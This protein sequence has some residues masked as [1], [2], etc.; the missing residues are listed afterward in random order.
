[1]TT[2]HATAHA[3]KG[4]G[5]IYFGF[6]LLHLNPWGL[7]KH[8]VASK[9]C[10]VFSRRLLNAR[11]F[12]WL[13]MVC[14]KQG[15]PGFCPCVTLTI[16]ALHGELQPEVV[17]RVHHPVVAG[18][19]DVKHQPPFLCS[20]DRPGVQQEQIWIP[21]AKKQSSQSARV[22]TGVSGRIL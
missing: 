2:D 16:D 8:K 19:G 17:L 9:S 15:V 6:F 5:L 1:M 10:C 12:P 3:K 18:G 22:S 13:G 4:W 7:P 21:E 20:P 14:L 11:C